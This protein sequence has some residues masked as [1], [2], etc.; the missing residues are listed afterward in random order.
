[1][2]GIYKITNKIN[3]KIYIGQST[4]IE[5]RWE[6]HKYYTEDKTTLLQKAFN[7]YGVS[8]FTFEVIEECPTNQLDEREKYWIN[9]YQSYGTNGYNMT[10]GGQE[11]QKINYDDIID[12]YLECKSIRETAES[13]HHSRTTVRTVL[14]TYNISYEKETTLPISIIMIDLY[15]LQKLKEFPSIVDAA[16][17]VGVT[18]SALRKYFKMN[19][20]LCGGYFW[21]KKGDNVHFTPLSKNSKIHNSTRA[22]P[23]YQYDQNNNLIAIHKSISAANKAMGKGRSNQTIATYLNTSHLV[24]GFYWK[25]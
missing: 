15:T 1:M 16:S 23:I 17:Y 9:Y 4:N 22:I 21:K 2:I 25:K 5:K 11:G 19:Q 24:Y 6:S 3:H 20:N 14:D 13:L 8:N 12:K 7:K 18:E 10:L